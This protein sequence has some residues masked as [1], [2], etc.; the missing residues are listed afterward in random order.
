[1]KV[2]RGLA[3]CC[4]YQMDIW[5]QYYIDIVSA[6]TSDL[7]VRYKYVRRRVSLYER[8]VLRFFAFIRRLTTHDSDVRSGRTSSFGPVVTPRYTYHRYNLKNTNLR[9][10]L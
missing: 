4:S 10:I 6:G 8:N 7:F 1:M 9:I 3:A 5:T 2:Q